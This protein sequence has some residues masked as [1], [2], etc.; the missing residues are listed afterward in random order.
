MQNEK[1]AD[2]IALVDWELRNAFDDGIFKMTSLSL[3]VS[4]LR[5]RQ[6][7]RFNGVCLAS[8]QTSSR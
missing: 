6:S 3:A 4:K 5:L 8:P 7:G 2:I 1:T